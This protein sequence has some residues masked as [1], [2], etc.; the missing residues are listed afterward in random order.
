MSVIQQQRFSLPV[1][2]GL[3]LLLA[4]C[5]TAYYGTMEK[6]GIHK[7]DI[8]SDR[9]EEARDSQQEAKEQ[10][11][12]ALEEFSALT[13]FS[14]GDLEA[15]YKRLNSE[16]E[17]SEEAAEAVHQHI[18]A[19]ESVAEALFDE[20]Q[21]ELKL[22]SSQKLRSSSE[23]KLRTTRQKYSQLLSTMKRAEKKIEPVLSVFRDQVLFL[24]HNLNAQAI[25]SLKSELRGVE[26]NVA[27]LVAA[28]EKSI[29]EADAFIRTLDNQ[30]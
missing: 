12:S 16:F 17:Q 26:I 7:R 18:A 23:Q 25:S 15:T 19:V 6:L 29:G 24:K 8:L 21:E 22:Y 27:S 28:M 9:V 2:C 3:V 4:G 30:G 1:I 14:G 13:N 10:F 11:K 5:Q 20:W